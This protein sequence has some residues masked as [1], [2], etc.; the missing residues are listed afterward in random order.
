[1]IFKYHVELLKK[2]G[3]GSGNVLLFGDQQTTPQAHSSA[4]TRK[5]FNDLGYIGFI[6]DVD[7]NGKA[8]LNWDLNEVLPETFRSRFDL[9]FD[10]GTLEHLSN[11]GAMLE[12]VVRAMRV[13]GVYIAE[14]PMY[15][16][17]QAFWGI[18]P[19]IHHDFFVANGFEILHQELYVDTSIRMSIQN[20]VSRIFPDKILDV[21]RSNVKKIPGSK[22]FIFKDP[23]NTLKIYK[24][25]WYGKQG[26]YFPYQT[27]C[28]VVAKKV[29]EVGKITW[30]AMNC[31]PKKIS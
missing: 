14:N 4:N 30:P 16:Y 23:T 25:G 20:F 21:L 13:S 27:R 24:K 28:V 5:L 1:M 12:S 10:G 2:Y 19:Q 11:P 9:S 26:Y 22:E 6:E 8:S 17:G 15:P 31:Y 29:R 3:P 7:Y 18:D